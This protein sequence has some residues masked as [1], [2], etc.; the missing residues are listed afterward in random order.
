MFSIIAQWHNG[1]KPAKQSRAWVFK[2][3]AENADTPATQVPSRSNI[4]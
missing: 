4:A 3:N 1:L 2:W